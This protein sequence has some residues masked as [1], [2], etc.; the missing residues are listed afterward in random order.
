MYCFSPSSV[1]QYPNPV[2]VV[3]VGVE[4]SKMLRD[5]SNKDWYNYAVEFCG[6]THLNRTS[7]VFQFLFV[8][9]FRHSFQY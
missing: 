8:F 1:E 9:Q 5:P 6:G 3:S 7:E 4:V 2:R